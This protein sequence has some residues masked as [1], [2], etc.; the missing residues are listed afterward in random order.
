MHQKQY[1]F[2]ALLAYLKKQEKSPTV[3]TPKELEKE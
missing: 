2:I 1:K 3:L